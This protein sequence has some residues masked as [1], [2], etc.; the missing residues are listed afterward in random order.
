MIVVL[1]AT[2]PRVSEIA[3]TSNDAPVHN[4][5]MVKRSHWIFNDFPLIMKTA[6]PAP[7]NPI[8]QGE[9]GI[10]KTY[11]LNNCHFFWIEFLFLILFVIKVVFWKKLIQYNEYLV[12]VVDTDALV[13]YSTRASVATMLSTNPLQSCLWVMSSTSV[14]NEWKYKAHEDW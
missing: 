3:I 7:I 4:L 13:L 14:Y 8:Q 10:L 6:Q 2:L 11:P 12:S 9:E 5:I 1:F